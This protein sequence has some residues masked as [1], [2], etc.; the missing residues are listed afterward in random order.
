MSICGSLPWIAV[1]SST[2]ISFPELVV[3]EAPWY[4]FYEYNVGI[5]DKVKLWIFCDRNSSAFG[6]SVC[7]KRPRASSSGR[8]LAKDE[9]KAH[10]VW[11]SRVRCGGSLQPSL[12]MSRRRVGPELLGR[13][14]LCRV[15]CESKTM[16]RVD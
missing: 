15:A 13:L 1:R 2:E 7:V 11:V 12:E 6:F 16:A 5:P 4:G 3:E 8:L 9:G 14:H 10:P